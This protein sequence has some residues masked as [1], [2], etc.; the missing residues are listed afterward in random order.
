[1]ADVLLLSF[2]NQILKANNGT[3]CQEWYF[4]LH[5]TIRYLTTF[6]TLISYKFS[7]VK[8]KPR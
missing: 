2:N 6:F 5:I 3:F 1:M 7:L 4:K 8:P